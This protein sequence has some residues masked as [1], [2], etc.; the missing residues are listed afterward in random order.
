[1]EAT[2]RREQPQIGVLDQLANEYAKNKAEADRLTKRN[3]EIAAQFLSVATFKP[4]SSTGRLTAGGLAFEITK[5]INETWNQP[6]L[7]AVR[8]EI[9]DE[10]FLPLFRFKWEPKGK[11]LKAFLALPG[12]NEI[13]AAILS[14]RTIT[15]GSPSVKFKE[16]AE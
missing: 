15:P 1:M 12:S 7:N 3:R 10:A 6:Q 14:A 11:E 5:T 16:A 9:T 13:K 8:S 4:G 2:A